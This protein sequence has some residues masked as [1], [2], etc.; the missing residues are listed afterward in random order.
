MFVCVEMTQTKRY[1][2]PALAVDLVVFGYYVE[3]LSVLLLN[4]KDAPFKNEW[5]LPGG[6]VHFADTFQET[7]SRILQTKLGIND[8]YLE[9]LYSFD[10]PSRDP[11]GR[12]IS[13]AYYALVNPTKFQLSAG[14]MTNDVQWFPVDK[15][16][17]LGFDHNGICTAAL[18]RLQAKIQYHPA[19]FELLDELFTM[20]EL[21]RLYETITGLSIDRR[22]FA[23]KILAAEYVLNTGLKREG[24]QNR[25]P[26]LFRFNKKIKPHQFHINL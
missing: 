18:A 23:R 19:G 25:H 20:S 8:V 15:I 2:N 10:E 14:A 16:P 24:S 12:V 21:H 26:E 17:V 5:T 22:N 13:V 1:N 11:R 6:F 3:E 7:C 4:R 9:Q